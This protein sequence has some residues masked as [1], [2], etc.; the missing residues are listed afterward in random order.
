MLLT[1]RD[2]PGL[3][4]FRPQNESCLY[5]TFRRLLCPFADAVA[6][7]R[8]CS[9]RIDFASTVQER[10]ISDFPLLH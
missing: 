5:G 4:I 9:C 6:K 7:E 3:H 1:Q 10:Q 8:H 2:Q